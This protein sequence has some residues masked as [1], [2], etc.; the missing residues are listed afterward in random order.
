MDD[1]VLVHY[2]NKQPMN[3]WNIWHYD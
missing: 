3:G 2:W 1:T